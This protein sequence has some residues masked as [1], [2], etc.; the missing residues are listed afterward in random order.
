MSSSECT[1]P[2]RYRGM[3]K[4]ERDQQPVTMDV[5]HKDP[6]GQGHHRLGHRAHCRVAS[7][8]MDGL[9][10]GLPAATRPPLVRALAGHSRLCPTSTLMTPMRLASF[11]EGASCRLRLPS[12]CRCGA[13]GTPRRH[14]ALAT[15]RWSGP[16]DY[17]PRWCG[18]EQVRARLSSPQWAR[19]CAV[20]RTD[21]QRQGC[22]PGGADIADLAGER[23]R[24]RHQGRELGD[25]R[26]L[27]GPRPVSPSSRQVTCRSLH[28]LIAASRPRSA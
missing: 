15:R 12:A 19:T 13:P 27:A 6:V 18:V 25:H 5:C 24:S 26:R 2:G 1:T 7:D 14:G 9:A 22:R 23:D 11:L 10:F 3:S 17:L 28:A 8:A 20:L 4:N 16:P 21:A